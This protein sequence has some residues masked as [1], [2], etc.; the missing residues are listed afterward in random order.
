[1]FRKLLLTFFLLFSSFIIIYPSKKENNNLFNYCYALEKILSRNS[2]E[3]TKNLSNKYKSFAKDIS[4]FGTKQTKGSFANKIIDQYKN[5]KDL[6]IITLVPNKIYCLAGY[7][8]EVTNP[9]L[10]QS[11]FYEKSKQKINE[12]KEI[13]KEVDNFVKEIYLDYESIKREINDLF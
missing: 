13:K 11:I 6:I 8:I 12:Y 9:G 1:M 10:F 2:L 5:S 7:W 4:L 3:N